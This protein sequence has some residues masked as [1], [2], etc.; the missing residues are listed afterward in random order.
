M[1]FV[2]CTPHNRQ[3]DRGSAARKRERDVD[4]RPVPHEPESEPEIGAEAEP[5]LLMVVEL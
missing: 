1:S 2:W 5:D 4:E 3:F